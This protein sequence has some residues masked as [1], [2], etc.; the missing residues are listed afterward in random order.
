MNCSPHCFYFII[1]VI[2]FCL[3]CFFSFHLNLIFLL[4]STSYHRPSL[5]LFHLLAS[6]ISHLAIK[7]PRRRHFL[8]NTFNCHR[9]AHFSFFFFFPRRQWLPEQLRLAWRSYIR[10][11]LITPH[12]L[13]NCTRTTTKICHFHWPFF[14]QVE[15]FRLFS[16][17]SP[18]SYFNFFSSY[19][20]LISKLPF[21]TFISI[22][23]FFL[24]IMRFSTFTLIQKQR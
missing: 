10:I 15:G 6:S 20:L 5:Y 8:S 11:T 21:I 14:G 22:F 9:L 2:I 12:K 7:K 16:T 23:L 18:L 17:I 19:F 3:C 13:H 4:L 1:I 24:M